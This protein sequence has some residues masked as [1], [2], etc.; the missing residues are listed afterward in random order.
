[1]VYYVKRRFIYDKLDL[2]ILK[3]STIIGKSTK[4]L[5]R[6]DR[7]L[8]FTCKYWQYI[9]Y[10]TDRWKDVLWLTC[11]LKL[12]FLLDSLKS[13]K[14]FSLIS[15]HSVGIAFFKI[16]CFGGIEEKSTS[17]FN[18]AE[19][20]V[21]IYQII[22]LMISLLEYTKFV[23]KAGIIHFS[24]RKKSILTDSIRRSMNQTE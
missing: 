14:N 8:K 19:G 4:G 6:C 3:A 15:S 16:I 18:L 1:M 21:W 2:K 22:S 7:Y 23:F 24:S 5:F 20:L 9:Q 17:K 12:N 10:L 13:A 11:L